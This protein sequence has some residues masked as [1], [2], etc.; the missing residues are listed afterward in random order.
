MVGL[1]VHV[2]LFI[3]LNFKSKYSIFKGDKINF[4]LCYKILGYLRNS[5]VI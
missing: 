2:W 3:K 5:L 4:G 1:L